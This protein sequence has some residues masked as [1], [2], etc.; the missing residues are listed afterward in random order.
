MA[1][2][3]F[4]LEVHLAMVFILGVDD[5]RVILLAVCATEHRDTE[6]IPVVGGLDSEGDVVRGA[7]TVVKHV[8]A[9]AAERAVAIAL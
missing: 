3:S 1:L 4:L 5:H 6:L 9:V 7:Q 8:S 2:W